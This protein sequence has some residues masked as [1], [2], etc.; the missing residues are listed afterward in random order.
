LVE[1]TI[2]FNLTHESDPLCGT[3]RLDTIKEKIGPPDFEFAPSGSSGQVCGEPPVNTD[4]EGGDDHPHAGLGPDQL[5]HTC[6]L[7]LARK[8]T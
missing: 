1:L 2:A 6:P 5:D 4:P 3:G 8:L 7:A